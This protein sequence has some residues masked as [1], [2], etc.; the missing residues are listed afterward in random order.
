MCLVSRLREIHAEPGAALDAMRRLDTNA[1]MPELL[2]VRRGVGPVMR[3][4]DLGIVGNGSVGLHL[5]DIAARNGV[6]SIRLVDP[7]SIKLESLLTHPCAPGDLRR[8]KALLAAERAKAVSPRTR[9]FAFEG[10]FEE[11][12]AHFLAGVSFLL[13]ASDNLRCEASVSQYALHFGIPVVQGSVYG[14]TLTAQ[15][16]SVTS[17][18]AGRGPCLACGFGEREWEELDRGT[19]FSCTGVGAP[20]NAAAERSSVPTAS[21]AHLCG[22]AAHL[23]FMDVTRLALGLGDPGESRLLEYCGYTHRTT[24]TPLARRDDCP[25]DHEQ[26]RLEPRAQDLGGSTLRALL[27]TAGYLEADP[28]RVTVTVERH[29]FTSL[30]ACK[31]DAPPRLGH[32]LEIGATAGVCPTCGLDRRPHPLHTFDEVPV[33]LLAEQLDRP[34]AELGVPSPTSIRFRGEAGSVLFHRRFPDT[35]DAGGPQ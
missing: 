3:E 14:R 2:D 23:A 24:V 34:L 18:P 12:P 31:C 8:S 26:F 19:I 7:A 20:S 10:A 21:L 35:D 6:R 1:R 13:L 22:L 17:A 4:L 9:V 33:A 32:F 5:A 29:C 30:A 27:R 15:V 11:L 28:L 16:R 25:L